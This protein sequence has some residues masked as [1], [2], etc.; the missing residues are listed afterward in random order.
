[1]GLKYSFR[2]NFSAALVCFIYFGISL[3]GDLLNDFLEE[4]KRQGYSDKVNQTVDINDPV[5]VDPKF[6]NKEPL[7]DYLALFKDNND[8]VGYIKLGDTRIDYPVV[9]TDNNDY[10]VDFAFDGSRSKSGAIYADYRNDFD[11]GNLSTNTILYGHNVSTGSFFAPLSNY[12]RTRSDLSF[13]KTNPIVRFDSLFDRMEWKVF[14]VMLGN[15]QEHFGEVYRYWDSDKLEFY[16]PDSFHNYIFDV[17]DRSILYT[18]VDIEYGDKILTLSTCFYHF[19]NPQSPGGMDTRV[20][21][22]ARKTRPG[23]NREVD[24]SVATRNR[25]V[26]V[27]EEEARRSDSNRW[28]G[29]DHESYW[30]Y[31]KYLTSYDGE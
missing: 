31:K 25:N 22:F 29:R 15:T 21:I 4:I 6:N 27:F 14:A 9:Q 5:R 8:L 2:G 28:R 23:E 20:V 7:E 12:Y 13:Y 16:D 3:G 18:D 1:M 11:N 19:G 10:Y 30:D 17:M 26:K 24:T